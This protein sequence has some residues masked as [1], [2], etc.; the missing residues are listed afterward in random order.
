MDRDRTTQPVSPMSRKH[1][2]ERQRND[3]DA[4]NLQPRR[5]DF[6]RAGGEEIT[7]P[8][9]RYSILRKSRGDRQRGDLSSLNRT[10]ERATIYRALNDGYAA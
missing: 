7:G 10:V 5:E 6:G 2:Q 8:A 1:R 4:V 3:A 9:D